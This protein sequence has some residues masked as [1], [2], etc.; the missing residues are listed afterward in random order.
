MYS[1]NHFFFVGQSEC[2]WGLLQQKSHL[3]KTTVSQLWYVSVSF[4]R[5]YDLSMF[6]D[7]LLIKKQV[8]LLNIPNSY[9]KRY[10]IQQFRFSAYIYIHMYILHMYLYH[11]SYRGYV[12]TAPPTTTLWPVPG[13][14]CC[15]LPTLSPTGAERSRS[16]FGPAQDPGRSSWMWTSGYCILLFGNPERIYR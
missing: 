8:V 15:P 2:K 11:H 5:W 14:S 10:N 9:C 4:V 12:P 3:Q 6:C 16:F 13:A 7:G 1:A